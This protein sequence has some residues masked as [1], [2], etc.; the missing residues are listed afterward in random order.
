MSARRPQHGFILLTVALAL[1]LV[2]AVAF[3][4]NRSGGMN[5]SMAAR[6]LQADRARYVAEAGLAQINYQTQSGLCLGY[7][8][9]PPETAFGA[10]GDSFTATVNPK[11]GSPV[12]LVATSATADGAAATLTRSNVSVYQIIPII[13]TLQ[14]PDSSGKDTSVN[15]TNP[16]SNYGGLTLLKVQ[17]ATYSA[18]IQFDLSSIPAG[19]MVTGATLQLLKSNIAASPGTIVVYRVTTPWVEGTQGGGLN[20]SGAT[21]NNSNVSTPWTTPGGDYHPAAV[22]SL[23]LI[24]PGWSSWDV[25]SLMQGWSAG[26]YPNYGMILVPTTSDVFAS[27]ESD[28]ESNATKHPKLIVTYTPPCG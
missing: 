28:D 12:T 26:S 13:A 8:D 21:Y 25:T 27:F 23:T 24:L 10:D 15:W 4:L 3:L 5:M 17:G 2:A 1:T 20:N 7:T 9:L 19:A 14:A 6:G 16:N 22:A 18:L 11:V